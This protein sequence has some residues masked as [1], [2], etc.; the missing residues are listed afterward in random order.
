MTENTATA[1]HVAKANERARLLIAMETLEAAGYTITPPKPRPVVV[2]IPAPDVVHGGGIE[3]PE[4]VQLDNEMHTVVTLA[5]FGCGELGETTTGE[6]YRYAVVDADEQG[7]GR[8]LAKATTA[9]PMAEYLAVLGQVL[10][11][12]DREANLAAADEEMGRGM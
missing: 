8:V 4:P 5:A 10:D 12:A 9:H 3:S 11:E 6:M 7:H 1:A 2:Y